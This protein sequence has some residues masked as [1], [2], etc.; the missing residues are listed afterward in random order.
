M[1]NQAYSVRS[2]KELKA[3]SEQNGDM[4]VI[5]QL[6]DKEL[7][8]PA[9]RWTIRHLI[10]YRLLV[11]PEKAFLA[12]LQPEHEECPICEEGL[13]QAIDH[14]NT[15]ALVEDAPRNLCPQL[16]HDLIRLPGGFF[17]IALARAARNE[18]VDLVRVHP[19]R[20]RIPVQRE[21]YVSSASAIPGSSPP[22][23]YSSS[24]EAD[25]SDVDEDEHDARR[26]KPE[27]VTV[28][29]VH[30]FLQNVLHLCLLQHSTGKDTDTDMGTGTDI[31]TD[32]E[33]RPRIERKMTSTHIAG[34]LVS[35]EDDGGLC[36]MRRSP[37]GWKMLHPYLAM[38]EAKKAFKHYSEDKA[39]RYMPIISNQN[40]AQYLGEA[41]ITW[42]ENQKFL[43]RGVFLIA[44][45]NTFV[46]FLH[47]R[48]GRD[49]SDYLDAID[50]Q[51][52]MRIVNDEQRDPHAY[53][54]STRWLNLQSGEGR[55]NALCHI[56]ALIRWHEDFTES[57]SQGSAY[58][59][60][61]SGSDSDSMDTNE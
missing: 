53:M 11:C 25:T 29:L 44:A 16:D 15:R 18:H 30:C 22:L 31:G 14:I 9:S 2:S 27:E 17:W 38:I 1:D 28:H 6:S 20:E 37:D 56:L 5:S 32:I 3:V 61:D 23:L 34:A 26:D 55:K 52:Q 21:G 46:R 54:H 59:S 49:Y 24:F 57:N 41:V 36:Q 4:Q 33:V 42:K 12:V 51:A 40:L 47:F 35:A 45:T 10:A 48:F 39:G 60:E 13:S 19:Q 50:K 8:S 7:I 58:R 43:Q